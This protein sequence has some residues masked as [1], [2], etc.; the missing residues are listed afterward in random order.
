LAIRA[1]GA[2]DRYRRQGLK[3]EAGHVHVQSLTNV[4]RLYQVE[5]P[6]LLALDVGGH[7]HAVIRSVPWDTW[8]PKVVVVEAAVP[9]STTASHHDWQPILLSHGY[10]PAA[11]NGVNRFYLRD[12]FRDRLGL[13]EVPVN[14]LDHFTRFETVALCNRIRWLENRVLELEN[15]VEQK[16][17]TLFS[18]EAQR[19]AGP[20]LF[21]LRG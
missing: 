6:D 17:H 15:A 9:L 10:L 18:R 16:S 20:R 8:R 7:E 19:S 4:I 2:A 14:A 3:V 5:S 12:D 13:F 21:A 1:S 11:F